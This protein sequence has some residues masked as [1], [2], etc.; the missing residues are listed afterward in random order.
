MTH[1]L[2]G[3]PGA[4]C[5]SLPRAMPSLVPSQTFPMLR[6]ILNLQISVWHCK[7]LSTRLETALRQ[8][9][10]LISHIGPVTSTL[11]DPVAVAA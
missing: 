4:R 3:S 5:G 11:L 8:R 2:G 10:K 6:R 7:T 1:E 9:N